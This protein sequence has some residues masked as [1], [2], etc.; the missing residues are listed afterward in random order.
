MRVLERL[1]HW[2]VRSILS[3]GFLSLSISG[4][5]VLT[6]EGLC[7]AHVFCEDCMKAWLGKG[8]ACPICRVP[9][10]SDQLQRFAMVDPKTQLPAAAP[11]R[12]VNNAPVPKSR[13]EIQYNLIEPDL[14]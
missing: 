5:P 13:R 11:A 6:V 7:S 10:E 2:M 14:F 4:H 1:H 12:I 9:I 8:K 3:W